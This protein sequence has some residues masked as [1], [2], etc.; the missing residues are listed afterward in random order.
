MVTPLRYRAFSQT[1]I[2]CAGSG[3]SI[4]MSSGGIAIEIGKVLEPGTEIELV[5]DWTGL[6]H[7]KRRMRLFVWGEVVRSEEHRT[8]VRIMTHDF[9]ESSARAVA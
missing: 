6:Y 4:D 9:R 2:T 3:Q 5:L 7:G 8:A 1:A